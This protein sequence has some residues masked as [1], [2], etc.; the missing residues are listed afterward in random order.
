MIEYAV[1]AVAA[2]YHP[3][4]S[5]N[6]DLAGVCNAY[7]TGTSTSYADGNRARVFFCWAELSWCDCEMTQ[8]ISQLDEWISEI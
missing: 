8:H 2:V 3:A 4:S 1:P 5:N 6:R 7:R